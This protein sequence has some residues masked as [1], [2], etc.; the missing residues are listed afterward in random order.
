MIRPS[1]SPYGA[2]ILF[3]SK[4]DGGL[5]MCTDYR[6]LNENTI[7]DGTKPAR[8][9]QCVDALASAKYISKIDLRWGYW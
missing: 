4:K 8:S 6:P 1:S 9:D 7:R 3:A 2:P 5:R